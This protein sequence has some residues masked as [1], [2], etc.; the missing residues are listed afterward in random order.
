MITKNTML[1]LTLAVIV[2]CQTYI[3]NVQAKQILFKESASISNNE[4]KFKDIA[5]LTG[6]NESSTKL[7]SNSTVCIS[8]NIGKEKIINENI[9]KN[10]L[11][12]FKSIIKNTE[13][14]IPENIIISRASKQ[15][16]KVFLKDI[17]TDEIL[18]KSPWNPEQLKITD[19][20]GLNNIVVQEGDLDFE[21]K[22]KDNH[23]FT[24][25]IPVQVSIIVNGNKVKH[26]WLSANLKV[27]VDA[28]ITKRSLKRGQILQ[29]EDIEVKVVNLSKIRGSIITD[30]KAVIG[31]RLTKNALKNQTLTENMIMDPPVFKRGD[32]VLIQASS[33]GLTITARGK[34]LGDG[35]LNK[36]IGVMNLQS[37][38]VVYGF[39]MNDGTVKISF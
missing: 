33:P 26:L 27:S 6:F 22:I 7:I 5:V 21:I 15:I 37:K 17:I 24:G 12:Q 20:R 30:L 1:K 18:N 3:G 2:L 4:V 9:I 38:K 25:R 34:A 28:I 14:D 32:E 8:P 36:S 16:S 23:T 11:K 19:I 39:V 29:A 10:I 31:K 35:Y 13:I